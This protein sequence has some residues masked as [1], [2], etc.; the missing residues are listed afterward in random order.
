MLVC[1]ENILDFLFL[2]YRPIS[3]QRCPDAGRDGR[4][5]TGRMRRGPTHA[6][7]E[8]GCP[9]RGPH[10]DRGRPSELLLWVDFGVEPLPTSECSEG[11]SERKFEAPRSPKASV[12][13][14]GS[15]ACGGK[16]CVGSL[17]KLWVVSGGI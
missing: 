7:G 5:R 3:I 10:A 15:G 2:N 6:G 8:G 1:F 14:R 9:A 4:R 11:S 16:H 17:L 13:R 12:R